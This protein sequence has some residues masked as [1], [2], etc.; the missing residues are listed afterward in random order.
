MVKN[1]K[2]SPILAFC[3]GDRRSHIA[4][5]SIRGLVRNRRHN[6]VI[7]YRVCVHVQSTLLQSGV[8]YPSDYSFI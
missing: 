3:G 1:M 4:V 6:V 2:I 5:V 8:N 7:Y